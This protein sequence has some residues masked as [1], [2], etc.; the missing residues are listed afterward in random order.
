MQGMSDP[1]VN[2]MK[3]EPA[4]YT[5]GWIYSDEL[6]LSAIAS[7]E[8]RK[9]QN[10]DQN[11]TRNI[12]GRSFSQTLHLAT[13]HLLEWGDLF[14]GDFSTQAI[15]SFFWIVGF[16]IYISNSEYSYSNP[17]PNTTP[18]VVLYSL[19]KKI[20]HPAFLSIFFAGF[21][22]LLYRS[23]LRSRSE[24][25]ALVFLFI[26]LGAYPSIQFDPRH[27]FHL[28]FIWILC[29]ISIINFIQN[30]DIYKNRKKFISFFAYTI[31]ITTAI[32]IF[33]RMSI[34]Y[35]I[36][37]LGNTITKLIN[38]PKV[39]VPL[40]KQYTNSGDLILLVPIPKEYLDLINAK[41][42]S[43]TEE[44]GNIGNEWDVRSGAERYLLTISGNSCRNNEIE[45]KTIYK[46][47]EKTWQAFDST[48]QILKNSNEKSSLLFPGFYRPTQYF[49]GLYI[50]S[51]YSHCN[52]KLEKILGV[53]RLPL[54]FI[55]NID[56]EHL[57]G[58]PFKNFGNFF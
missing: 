50:P 51:T 20:S 8:R 55:G 13:H 32:Y 16:P 57:Y 54:F 25:F 15:K 35:Q 21:I 33:N 18:Q 52:F 19:Y 7:S 14:M 44:L 58:S 1:F 11:E 31:M 6:T 41:N 39:E 23:Y 49:E 46:H 43:L 30:N 47:S 40:S 10:W 24:Y 9:D 5:T 28:E 37:E 56:L 22:L 42:D 26:F 38:T 36:N 45:I 27:F 17:F 4:G 53:S 12:P 29:L 34:Q 3:L 2:R 48:I